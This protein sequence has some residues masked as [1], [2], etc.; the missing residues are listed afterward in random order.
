MPGFG[1]IGPTRRM[2]VRSKW[3]SNRPNSS[4]AHVP[5]S[6]TAMLN[7]SYHHNRSAVYSSRLSSQ[8]RWQASLNPFFHPT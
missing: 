5:G 3:N 7:P 8:K 4:F 2:I 1:S 6:K